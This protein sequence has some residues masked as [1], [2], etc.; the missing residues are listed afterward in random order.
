MVFV[1]V[2]GEEIDLRRQIVAGID[3][4][5][6]RH[7][8]QLAVAQVG[9]GISAPDAFR[10]RAGIAAAGPDALSLLAHHDRGAGVLAHRQDL[11]GRDVGVLQHVV[12]DEAVVIGRFGIV[13]DRA[14]L[15]QMAGAQQMLAID[16][17]LLGQER[18][19]RQLYF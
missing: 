3:L 17:R 1:A 12:G 2:V 8:R 9:L 11:S 5:E 13:E 4:A 14:Q 19:R 7:R 18:Q 16:H 6:H 15:A 10:E